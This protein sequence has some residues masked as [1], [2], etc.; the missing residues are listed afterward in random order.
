MRR[1]LAELFPPP[2]P[3]RVDMPARARG[4]LGYRSRFFV[5]SPYTGGLEPAS[6]LELDRH[7]A[8][9]PFLES[10]AW[11]SACD[12][13]PWPDE[14][15]DQPDLTLKLAER[16]AVVAQQARG[17][18]W[19][20][21]RRTRHSR[22]HL[23][24][25][26]HHRDIFVAE[27]RYRPSVHLTVIEAMNTHFGCDYPTDLP[28]DAVAA[29]L[30][31]QFDGAAD[32]EA[33]LP[34]AEDPEQLAGLLYVLSAL[35]HDDPG[36]LAIYRSHLEHPAAVVR[37]TL[38][39]IAMAYNYEALLEEMSLREPDPELRAELESL[40]D[41]GIPIPA[42]DPWSDVGDDDTLELDEGDVLEDAEEPLELDDGDLLDA[43]EPGRKGVRR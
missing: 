15:P 1:A 11:G 27:V 31:F 26:V 14:I 30:G 3:S 8:M 21:T 5:P 40:L 35:R 34:R 13:D 37:R 9:N 33:E 29:L 36:V 2:R 17:H 32:L 43:D 6:I 10:A 38:G 42:D 28:V 24:I 12:D 18:V 19:S 16:Q 25:E 22:S 23:T 39:D 20:L 41:E 7:F 4:F